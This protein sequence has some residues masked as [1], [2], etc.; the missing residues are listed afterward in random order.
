MFASH[1]VVVLSKLK[2]TPPVRKDG[3]VFLCWSWYN[4]EGRI[5]FL[6]SAL[7][8]SDEAGQT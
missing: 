4:Q 2:R 8:V 6:F 7:E 5:P 1:A 3:G